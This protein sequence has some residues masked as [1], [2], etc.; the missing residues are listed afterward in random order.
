MAVELAPFGVLVNAVAPG[1]VE[2]RSTAMARTRDD[3]DV[4]RH[5]LERT[6][7]GRFNTPEEIAAAVGFLATV[8]GMTGQTVCVDN[9]F[10]AAGLAYF[11]RARDRLVGGGR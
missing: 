8:E 6:P 11:G 2:H 10:M 7:L 3:A 5:D 1:I 4:H 9:G